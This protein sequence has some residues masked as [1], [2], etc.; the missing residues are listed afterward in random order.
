MDDILMEQIQT[1][2]GISQSGEKDKARKLFED[3]L[4]SLGSD[5]LHHCIFAHYMADVQI[6]LEKE[7][8]WDLKSCEYLEKLTDERLKLFHN[9]LNRKGFYASIY[10]NIA[11]DYLKLHKFADSMKYVELAEKSSADL[12]DDGYGNMIRQGIKRAKDRMRV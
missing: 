8:Y 11:N 9:S 12:D 4:P 5:P 10:L 6:E 1:V 3:L 2:I 7:L